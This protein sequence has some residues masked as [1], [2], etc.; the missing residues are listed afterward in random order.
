MDGERTNL[1][2]HHLVVETNLFQLLTFCIPEKLK[3]YEKVKEGRCK[4]KEERVNFRSG[5]IYERNL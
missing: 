1:E 3:E 4:E 5:N 2:N